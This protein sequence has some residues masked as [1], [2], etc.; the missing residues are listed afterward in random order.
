HGYTPATGSPRSSGSRYIAL[1][2]WTA[3]PAAPFT[4]LSSTLTTTSLPPS[5]VIV[6]WTKQR[7]EPSVHLVCGAVAT[8]R[9][10]GSARYASS[11]TCCTISFVTAG[12]RGA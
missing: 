6:G 1:A 8:T 11:Y 10:K 9:V 2:H 12:R 7:L 4:R 5:W 3:C